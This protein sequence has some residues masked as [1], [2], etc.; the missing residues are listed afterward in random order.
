MAFAKKKSYR[1][2]ASGRKSAIKKLA[3]KV[4]KLYKQVESKHFRV[5]GLG[6]LPDNN[7]TLAIRHYPNISQGDIDYGNRIGDKITM[8]RVT[9]RSVWEH[10]A[11]YSGRV[12]RIVVFVMKDNSDGIASAWSTIWNL[13]SESTYANSLNVVNAGHDYDN[14]GNFVTLYDKTMCFNPDI[15]DKA[16]V[17]KWDFS[18][19]IPPRLQNVQYFAGGVTVVKNELFI[20]LLQDSDTGLSVNYVSEV[21]YTDM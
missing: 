4:N 3:K 19:T 1:R 20:A 8:K 16:K 10:G 17:Y 2:K 6:A 5:A 14:R 13:Y 15:A 18:L 7:P 21:F 12:G 11:G 9:F